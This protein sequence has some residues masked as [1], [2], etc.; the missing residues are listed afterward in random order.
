MSPDNP[1]TPRPEHPRPDFERLDWLNLN[2]TWGFRYDP[3]G[4]GVRE[5]W[6]SGN[7]SQFHEQI[8]VPY[9]W[10]SKLSEQC[11]PDYRRV[12]SGSMAGQST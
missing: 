8:V 5:S 6:F 2:G 7:G 4:R 3:E 10:Q 11:N 1:T 9:A 12:K